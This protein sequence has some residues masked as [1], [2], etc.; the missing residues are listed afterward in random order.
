VGKDAGLGDALLHAIEAARQ[1]REEQVAAELKEQLGVICERLPED[2]FHHL[3]DAEQN[4]RRRKWR[5]ASL[6]YANAVETALD[7]WLKMPNGAGPSATVLGDWTI[8]LKKIARQS[9][10]RSGHDRRIRQIYEPRYSKSLGEALDVIRQARVPRAHGVQRSPLA[11]KVQGIVLGLDQ[12]G[13]FELI[14][15]F[16]RRWQG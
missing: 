7:D 16:A 9:T 5:D 6:D 4:M 1:Q 15:R 3:F 10:S 14:L 11:H 13:V 8:I 12:V 2:A